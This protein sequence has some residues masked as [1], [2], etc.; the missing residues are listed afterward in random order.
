M[1]TTWRD[2][3][4]LEGDTAWKR[5]PSLKGTMQMMDLPWRRASPWVGPHPGEGLT[6][7]RASPWMAHYLFHLLLHIYLIAEIK[8]DR[9][10]FDHIKIN[11][12]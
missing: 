3:H 10:Q 12:G 4:T 9:I 7:G 5:H 11:P 6:L 2:G 8:D 1:D